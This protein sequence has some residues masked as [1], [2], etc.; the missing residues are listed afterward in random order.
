MPNIRSL[1]SSS[2]RPNS[3]AVCPHSACPGPDSVA[4]PLRAQK[5]H[6]RTPTSPLSATLPRSTHV[7]Q[8]SSRT[9]L[10]K[11]SQ[12]ESNSPSARLPPE[13]EEFARASARDDAALEGSNAVAGVTLLCNRGTARAAAAC[14]L[15][16]QRGTCTPASAIRC[17]A[18]AAAN[19]CCEY[20]YCGPNVERDGST[21]AQ[22]AEESDA[23]KKRRKRRAHDG[24]NEA[25][26]SRA[27]VAL[28]WTPLVLCV[29]LLLLLA[30]AFLF[31]W[32][33]SLLRGEFPLE[34][35]LELTR[36]EVAL[37]GY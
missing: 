22:C 36:R 17:P 4:R 29:V 34:S 3:V 5:A 35:L 31:T 26:G 37:C 11:P 13:Q 15:S 8:T 1:F 28:L 19:D 23:P 33:S 32:R 20:A 10:R 12:S 18:A 24:G 7:R 6:L 25:P 27:S 14:N 2:P 16:P 9:G 30:T 21:R